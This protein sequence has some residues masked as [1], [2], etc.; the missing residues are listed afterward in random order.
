MAA[1]APA[2]VPSESH[3]AL[4]VSHLASIGQVHELGPVDAKIVVVGICQDAP[5]RLDTKRHKDIVVSEVPRSALEV[6]VCLNTTH[7]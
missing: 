4:G 3:S 1:Q 6:V 2:E 5:Q 7:N